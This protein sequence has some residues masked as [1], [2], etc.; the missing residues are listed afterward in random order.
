VKEEHAEPVDPAIRRLTVHRDAG[1]VLVWQGHR[2]EVA[3]EAVRHGGLDVPSWS[4][5][6]H[7][8]F[9][10]SLP[11]LLARTDWGRKPGRE[12][13][14]GVWLD[15]EALVRLLRQAVHDRCEMAVYGSIKAWRL[16]SRWAQVSIGWHD[17]PDLAGQPTGQQTPR[18]GVR[19]A[20]LKQFTDAV[21]GVEDWTDAVTERQ[22]TPPPR[23][24]LPLSRELARHLRGQGED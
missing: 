19:Q 13:T 20:A 11:A 14:L 4:L 16:A 6:R 15:E 17:E 9:R 24:A 2:A 12:H 8:R 21:V 1:R 18:L 7:T 10:L 3:A 22:L 23:E 5:A